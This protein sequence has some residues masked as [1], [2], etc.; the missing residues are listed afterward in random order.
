MKKSARKKQ[1][2][3][4]ELNGLA[5]LRN[6]DAVADSDP[7]VSLNMLLHDELAERRK[8]NALLEAQVL[9]SE[10][11]IKA[12][13]EKMRLQKKQVDDEV[14]RLRQQIAARERKYSALRKEFQEST[15]W[16]LTRPVRK[17]GVLTRR[18]RLLKATITS[19]F[20]RGGGLKQSVRKA[21]E[22]YR[23]EGW[24]GIRSRL[25]RHASDQ[26]VLATHKLSGVALKP[27]QRAANLP[28]ERR[29]FLA[30]SISPE[31]QVASE[32]FTQA[33]AQM[34]IAVV[35]HVFHLDVLP[36]LLGRLDNIKV[37]HDV[38]MTV[39]PDKHEALR[40]W[41]AES[42]LDRRSVEIVQVDNG[43]YD[44]LPFIKMLP[45]VI[46][47]KYDLVCK[48][49]TKK[50]LANLEKLYPEAGNAW[51]D[52][53]LNPLMGSE[54]AVRQV[55]HAFA[56]QP[57][58]GMLG[59]ADFY[60]SVRH[61][62]YGNEVEVSRFVQLLQPSADPGQRWG[63]FAGSIFWSR[64][65]LLKGLVDLIPALE[66]QVVATKEQTGS[67]SSAWHALERVM[68][69]LPS[70]NGQ[71]TA[72]VYSADDTGETTRVM[73][74]HKSSLESGSPY[75][76]GASLAGYINL[77]KNVEFL[78]ERAEFS[79]QFYL[80]AYPHVRTLAMDAV[81]HYL[82]YGVYERCNP[83]PN[84]DSA[85][86]W[87]E[88]KDTLNNRCNPLIHY[89]QHGVKE[90]RSCFPA[91]ENITALM[92]LVSAT[93]HFDGKAYL[94]ANPDVAR[95]KI[96]PLRHY[97]QFGWRE[98]R[99]PA[100]GSGFDAIW[101]ASEYLEQ[102]RSPIN[103]LVHYAICQ[104]RQSLLRRPARK[105]LDMSSGHRLPTERKA[106]RVCLFAGY[107]PD[108]LIDQYVLD[109]I[110]ELQKYAD[111][112]YLADGDLQPG[113]L[114]KLAPITKGA[115]AFRHGE[116]DFG[117]YSRL[118]RDLVGWEVIRT[119]DEMLLVN[120]SSYLLSSLK[121]V[122]DKMDAKSCDWWGLQATK[123]LTATR[124]VASNRFDEKIAM[125]T[126]LRRLVPSYEKDECYDFHIGSYFLAFRAPVLEENGVLQQLLDSVRKERSKKNIV[127]RYEIGM[128][129][130][131]LLAGHKPATFI[132]HLYPFHPIYTKYHYDLIA[133]GFPLFKRF[134]LTENHYYVP[135][136][137]R[138]KQWVN[139]VL[140][141]ADL[142]AAERNLLRI[143]NADK[144]YRSLNI[145]ADGRQWPEPL[146]SDSQFVKEDA[147][148]VKDDRCWAFPVCAYDH[149]LGGNDRMVFESVKNDPNIRKVILT[150]SK[151]VQAEG[152]NVD[153]V[154]LKSL[155][156]QRLLMQSRYIFVKHA[157]RIN[158]IFPLDA[159]QHRFI[160]LWHGIPLKR[161]GYASLDLQ[162][163]LQS[164]SA[165][166]ARCHSVI[167]S[168]KIDRMAMA[169][170]FYPLNFHNI[171]LTGLP[172]NDVILR[173]ETLLPVDFQE[174]LVR[175]RQTLGG[176][177]LVLFAPTFRNAQAEGYYVFSESERQALA[178]CL[179]KH[180]AVLG[181]REHMADKA[182]SYS[183]ALSGVDMPV[184]SLD[185]R[186]FA[187]IELL[188][189]ESDLLITDYSSCF[190][191]FML[192]GKPEICFAYD[193]ESYAG[194][195]RGLF[196][197]LTDVFPGPVCHDFRALLQ[198]LDE[199]LA[200]QQLESKISYEFKR[201]I[202]FDHVDDGN[203]QR[204]LEHV[205]REMERGSV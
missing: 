116:Y 203:T 125:E 72:L 143:G 173:E 57:D 37:E 188:Y 167:A 136:L 80:D 149:L 29:A 87:D 196:Y 21:L 172:R 168:S 177:R 192:T 193:Y 44:I 124:D 113:E 86:Y 12:E 95:A 202:F 140:P 56:T 30:Q 135:E 133:E 19:L 59:S 158:T 83:N 68:G 187:D 132:D 154:P 100:L 160:N 2:R 25:R 176:R 22:V 197:E 159:K 141:G 170:A 15:S 79:Q 162:D 20:T 147:V 35:I 70:L 99:Q 43:G 186:Y 74:A 38:F 114:Q 36:E 118:A 164:I 91:A 52:L 71:H 101:Y 47:G 138:W 190:I 117:S 9:E 69:L 153:I 98:L 150:R 93:G 121:P 175:L 14:I 50:G 76:V 148:T 123:G 24:S 45:R 16:R 174:Q 137:W 181:V 119:Y 191:D 107:D 105:M 4:S 13:R 103:P 40:A 1:V 184:I 51:L 139:E 53:L 112:Y 89:L 90:G 46:E 180:N 194:S 17:F 171:W 11:S 179:R 31:V 3:P 48:L 94:Q 85:W 131:L 18:A 62:M 182:N 5:V 54:E 156:G 109:F 39:A 73:L 195:E 166:H 81:V 115:W 146:L 7:I 120:D 77:K 178:E 205:A 41:M 108:G 127:L 201:K 169:S 49:H 84:F 106:R 10:E 122:F 134:F 34:R 6:R 185:R 102:W 204:V 165:E 75:S 26:S 128:T 110:E 92:A 88:N 183:Q 142:R 42:S 78:R 126:V 28:L 155:A 58:L 144:L 104:Q 97:S 129:R 152:V 145:P 27:A 200:G 60:K 163:K 63:F 151:C 33:D 67:I 82:R 66:Q 64:P 61:L 157:P 65:A 198:S 130:R 32:L 96:E 161:I 189:R 23:R 199:I 55:L 111:V 8:E